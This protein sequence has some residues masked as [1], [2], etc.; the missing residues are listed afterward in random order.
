MKFEKSIPILYSEDVAK[1]LTFY[2]DKLGFGEK[3]EW[4]NPPTFGGVCHGDVEIFFSEKG[5]GNPGTWVFI[6]VENVDEYYE[7]IKL[8]GVNIIAPPNNKEWNMRELVV[9]DPD[10]HIIRFG[11]RIES[12]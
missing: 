5:H 10:G 8:K 9:A 12:D 1:S 11:Q 3:W 2:I 6:V 4:D 7:S